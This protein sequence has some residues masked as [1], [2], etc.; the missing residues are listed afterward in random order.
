[1]AELLDAL[2]P[3]LGL[4]LLHF[5]WQG[6]LIGLLAAVVLDMLRNARPQAR[7]AVA[8]LALLACMLAPVATALFMLSPELLATDFSRAFATFGRDVG[9]AGDG[10]LSA[11]SPSTA[12]FHAYLPAIVATWAAGTCLLSMR[13]AL[14]LT[15]V[16]RLRHL[17]QGPAQLVWQ[18]R[19]DAIAVHFQLRRC[20]A[21]RVVDELESPA[22]AGWWRP[23]VLL[24]AGLLTR[25]PT[26]LVEALLAHELAHIRR[27]DYLVNLL[28]NAIEALLFYHPVVW[29]LS[30]RIHVERE[31]IADQ[32]A[33]ELACA[34]RALARALSELSDLQRAAPAP[35]RPHRASRRWRSPHVP[36]PATPPPHPPHQ[37]RR[38][39][40]FPAAGSRRR[41]HGDL[42]LGA[43][44]AMTNRALART[45][46][47]TWTASSTATASRW[48]AAPTMRCT[49]GARS[50][51]STRSSPRA[52]A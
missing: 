27:H 13:M 23:V 25:M 4:A 22:S 51:T 35:A 34:P 36:H 44:P 43:E 16:R 49:C 12:Q 30:H 15:W 14:G 50:T 5:L 11:L 38:P 10:A 8:C 2:V 42:Q 41:R 18:S 33:A 20:V 6:A 24:P 48:F 32:L 45:G 21:L 52:R 39:H 46:H 3:L 31:Q 47:F 9:A 28:Q 19:L 7:Y 37:R 40:R 29:W 1:M 26:A 17:P